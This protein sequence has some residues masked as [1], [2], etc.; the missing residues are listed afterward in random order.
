MCFPKG[1]PRGKEARTESS[2]ASDVM[3]KATEGFWVEA[4]RQIPQI[5]GMSVMR[6][7]GLRTTSDGS[8]AGSDSVMTVR[9]TG[10]AAGCE[11]SE[12]RAPVS[13]CTGV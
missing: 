13:C 3:G 5:L 10:P 6:D 9:V 2:Q 11:Q 4:V 12:I 8:A 7:Q 1:V